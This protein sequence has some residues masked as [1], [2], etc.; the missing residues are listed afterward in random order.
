MVKWT[1]GDMV[2]HGTKLHYYRSGGLKLPLVMIHG[3]TDDGLCWLPVAEVLSGEHDVILVDLRGHG[4]SEAPDDGYDLKTVATEVSGLMTG[5]GLELPVLI[6]HSLGA[7]T[8]LALG[9][10]YP[11]QPGALILEDPPAFW[12]PQQPDAQEAGV[13]AWM[14]EWLQ[15]LKRKTRDEL[16][17]MARQENPTWS[18]AE[19]NPWADSKQRFS[20][21]IVKMLNPLQTV[22]DD[23][24]S[25]L[26]EITC[27]VLL[28][29]ADPERGAI[30]SDEAAA[31]LQQIIPHLKREHI[32]DAGH[33][34]RREQ[35]SRYMEIIQAFL[36]QL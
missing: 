3:I 22:P 24:S 18:E 9:G 11:D 17:E 20:P 36:I 7:V 4:K 30:V 13:H 23:F 32:S 6:G 16:L 19:L 12:S 5:L 15:E 21:K 14:R 8:A 35:F 34:I 28:I 27:P 31:E 25:R 26:S 33:N 1:T 10:F 2:T 29:T